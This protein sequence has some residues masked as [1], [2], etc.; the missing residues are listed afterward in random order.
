M[1]LISTEQ[2]LK[3]S[4]TDRYKRLFSYLDTNQEYSLVEIFIHLFCSGKTSFCQSLKV[5][6]FI[7][8]ILSQIKNSIPPVL[9]YNKDAGIKVIINRPLSTG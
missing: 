8:D 2:L 4:T 7:I 5:W 1:Y 6:Q 9:A 3:I